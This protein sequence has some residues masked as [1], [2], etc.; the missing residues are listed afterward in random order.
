MH[1]GRTTVKSY[2]CKVVLKGELKMLQVDKLVLE[3]YKKEAEELGISLTEYLL[4][5]IAQRLE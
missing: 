3:Q 1:E 4:F 2:S 5:V